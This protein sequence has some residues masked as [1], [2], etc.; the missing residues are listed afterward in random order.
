MQFKTQYFKFAILSIFAVSNAFADP[1]TSFSGRCTLVQ[2]QADG[3]VTQTPQS[4]NL[5]YADHSQALSFVVDGNAYTVS[6]SKQS[7]LSPFAVSF[8]LTAKNNPSFVGTG[9]S[10]REPAPGVELDFSA[11]FNELEYIQCWGSVSK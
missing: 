6:V 11:S 5:G 7:E 8:G 1:F 2:V 9:A 10:N 4:F 3:S